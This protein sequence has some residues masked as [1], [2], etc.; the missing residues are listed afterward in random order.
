MKIKTLAAMT[1][2]ASALVVPQAQAATVEQQLAALEAHVDRLQA[3][4]DGLQRRVHELQVSRSG[5]LKRLTTDDYFRSCFH[6][7]YQVKIEDFV[8]FEVPSLPDW[9]LAFDNGKSSNGIWYTALERRCVGNTW[10]P[11]IY[12]NVARTTNFTAPS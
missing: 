2:V 3:S 7:A 12:G 11:T 1:L 10:F 9:G 6:I 8:G 5:M 4:N